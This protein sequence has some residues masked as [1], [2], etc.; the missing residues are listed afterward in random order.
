MNAINPWFVY[1]P[2]IYTL[3]N[4]PIIEPLTFMKSLNIIQPALLLL[5]GLC[6]IV[7]PVMAQETKNVTVSNFSEVHV[8]TGLEL[9]L[10]QGATE[11]AR[12]IATENLIDAVVVEQNGTSITVKWKAIRSTKKAWLKRTAKVY[13]TYKNLNVIDASE[14]SS[15]KTE[16][17]L[18]AEILKATVASGAIINANIECAD[19]RL[20]T[21]S[22]ASIVLTGNA[23]KMKLES[24]SGS[25]VSAQELTVG[26]ADV[27]V[28]AGA[29][30][31]INVTKEL[32]ALADS[33]GNIRYKGNAELKN[34]STSK[35][36]SI[37]K[38]N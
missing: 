38:L 7:P 36:G 26:Y 1:K 24:S 29:D 2:R 9:I 30:V 12:I 35:S 10:T 19:F 21:T 28:S 13:I 34:Y 18:K 27:E 8:S 17:T 3:Y 5:F 31:K 4:K 37:K 11:S 32:K 25:T 14:G 22:G 6:F 16:N 15:I 23:A 20:Q 33:G